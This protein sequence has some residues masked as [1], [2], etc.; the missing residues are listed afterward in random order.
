MPSNVM[1]LILSYVSSIFKKMY[2]GRPHI[3]YKP[4]FGGN[5]WLAGWQVVAF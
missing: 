3:F 5:Y 4:I 2:V 1:T